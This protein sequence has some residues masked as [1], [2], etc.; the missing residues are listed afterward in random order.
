MAIRFQKKIK[1]PNGMTANMGK[2]GLNSFSMK[3][4]GI[5]VNIGKDGS[6]YGNFNYG[7]GM[8][9]RKKLNG[10]KKVKKTVDKKDKK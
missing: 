5:T 6:M 2:K 10:K 3:V 7:G 1:L 4:G 8:S 9:E